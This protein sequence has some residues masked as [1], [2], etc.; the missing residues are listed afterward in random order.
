MKRI[1][2]AVTAVLLAAVV[3]VVSM[4]GASPRT[5]HMA[6]LDAIKEGD[7]EMAVSHLK[8]SDHPDAELLLSQMYYV[9]NKIEVVQSTAEGDL[10]SY[11]NYVY[12]LAGQLYKH[13]S[14]AVDG[15]LT[16]ETNAYNDLGA[17][18]LVKTEITPPVT[19]EEQEDPSAEEDEEVTEEDLFN[20]SEVEYFYDALGNLLCRRTTDSTGLFHQ[21]RYTYD[22]LGRVVSEIYVDGDANWTRREY[23]YDDEGRKLTEE[24]TDYEDAWRNTAYTYKDG[25]LHSETEERADGTLKTVYDKNGKVLTV[26]YLHKGKEQVTRNTYDGNG[27][28]LKTEYPEGYVDV[29]RYNDRGLLTDSERQGATGTMV[30]VTSCTYDEDGNMLTRVTK[31]D[32]NEH[33]ETFTYNKKGQLV[34]KES[35]SYNGEITTIEILYER[36]DNPETIIETGPNGTFTTTIQWKVRYYPDGMP[37]N[38][39]EV[40]EFY[41]VDKP[42]EE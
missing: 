40:Y 28:L 36:Y 14:T 1:V 22:A 39:R 37:D 21:Y 18:L 34:K 4:L 42:T 23:T 13:E 3:V 32:G 6:A 29:Y 2:L 33:K 10:V 19:E 12:N 15:T 25:V 9:P 8:R 16:V 17:P 41:D 31:V 11:E 5:V 20:G 24:Y 27:N 30:V 35:V 38:V 7:Y 26:T